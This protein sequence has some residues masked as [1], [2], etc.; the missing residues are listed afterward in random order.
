MTISAL[1]E[2]SETFLVGL[3]RDTKLGAIHMKH[4]M[5]MP[6]DIQLALRFHSEHYEN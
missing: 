6:K 4:E 1:Q 5:I 3:F 2:G